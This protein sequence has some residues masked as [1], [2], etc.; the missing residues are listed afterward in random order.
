M[1]EEENENIANHYIDETEIR[2][3]IE[4]EEVFWLWMDGWIAIEPKSKTIL[5][6]YACVFLYK[7][8]YLLLLN[9]FFKTCLKSMEKIQFLLMVVVVVVVRGPQ[10]CRFLKLHHHHIHSYYYEKKY[11]YRERTI[12][13]MIKD[14]TE[15]FDDYF[16]CQKDNC[17]L[18]HVRNWFNLFVDVY[19]S[20]IIFEVKS[21]NFSRH[22]HLV[23]HYSADPL[24]IVSIA[25]MFKLI[26]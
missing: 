7:V 25:F 12:Q 16:P 13:Y 3:G 26:G 2:V 20:M 8:V 24:H 21:L 1:A 10:A 14:R 6:M 23:I 5:D 11:Q 4:R 18:E 9:S 19:N 17:T 15:M 22:I